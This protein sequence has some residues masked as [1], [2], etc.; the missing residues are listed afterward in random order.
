MALWPS[1]GPPA[2]LPDTLD[3]GGGRQVAVTALRDW[4][5]DVLS[6]VAA[7]HQLARDSELLLALVFVTHSLTRPLAHSMYSFMLSLCS[8]FF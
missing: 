7:Q 3:L 1:G 6:C 8:F 5:L 4:Q 2:Q